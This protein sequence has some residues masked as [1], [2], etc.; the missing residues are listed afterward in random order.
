MDD[1]FTWSSVLAIL[2]IMER[3]QMKLS[4]SVPQMATTMTEN[5]VMSFPGDLPYDVI[6]TYSDVF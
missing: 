3:Q 5:S 6:S 2:S 4:V 1:T